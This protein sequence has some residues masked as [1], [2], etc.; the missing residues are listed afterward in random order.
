MPPLVRPSSP[1]H[2]PSKGART[3]NTEIIPRPI[4]LPKTGRQLIPELLP[5]PADCSY[6]VDAIRPEDRDLQKGVMTSSRLVQ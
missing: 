3:P 4:L 5:Y 2:H 6:L 1:H